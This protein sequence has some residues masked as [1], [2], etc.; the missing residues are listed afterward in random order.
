MALLFYQLNPFDL[1]G[2][3]FLMLYVALLIAACFLA[4]RIRKNL[5]RS[6]KELYEQAITL[7]AYEAAYLRGGAELAADTA[8]ATLV[9]TKALQFSA[10]SNKLSTVA[11]GRPGIHPLEQAIFQTVRSGA[12]S[13]IKDV[14]S[15]A[16]E[17]A[18]RLSARL[19]QLGLVPTTEHAERVARVPAYIPWAVLAFGA[20]KLVIGYWRNR[21]IT[22][23]FIL[24]LITWLIA[25]GFRRSRPERTLLGDRVL[26]QI[27]EQNA[28]LEHTAKWKP[29]MLAAG[30]VSLALALFGIEAVVFADDTWRG[31]RDAMM[32]PRPAYDSSSSSSSSCGSSSC[33]SGCGGGGGCGG[34]GG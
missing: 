30:D 3:Q 12:A 33:S 8:L 28:A 22:F 18:E 21:P 25:R 5:L 14:R 17:D 32:P 27:K 26:K 4:W 10:A 15:I 9:Q 34:C 24:C 13:D 2:P 19:R 31:L 1:P 7:D 29:E 16:K 23:L 20:V 11:G 6:D